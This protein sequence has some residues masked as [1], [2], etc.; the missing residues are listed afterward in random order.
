MMPTKELEARLRQM[1]FID[2]L[3][4]KT[5]LLWFQLRLDEEMYKRKRCEK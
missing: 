2:L 1:S 4:L 5:E 3:V